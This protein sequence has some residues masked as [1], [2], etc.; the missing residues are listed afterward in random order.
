LHG[1]ASV[2]DGAITVDGEATPEIFGGGNQL[3]ATSEANVSIGECT[4]AS[5]DSLRG[6]LTPDGL[7]FPVE[8]DQEHCFGSGAESFVIV[9]H[10][11]A[12]VIV[13][14]G[15]NNIVTNGYLRYADNA[16]V[17][18]TLLAPTPASRVRIMLGTEATPSVS[19]IGHGDETLLDLVRP[20]VWMA[21]T[22][23]ALAF[24]VFCIARGV[25]PGRAVRE[26]L[27]TPIAGNELVVATGNLMQ[28]AQHDQ[29]AGWLV[30]G[31]LYR[32]L[33]AHYRTPP[34]IS[35]DRL[36]Q[37]VGERTGVDQHELRAVLNA[38]PAGDSTVVGGGLLQLSARI[39][40][41][42]ARTLTVQRTSTDEAGRSTSLTA[43]AS[44]R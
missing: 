42:R 20:G 21:L 34:G 33:V 38:G 25:R 36:A 12:V 40:N 7:L 10:V 15:D 17:V 5:L 29:R 32:Q 9:R 41:L 37:L 31:E 43:Q 2:E 26:L 28:R 1:G 14:L 23:L 3:P 11:G 18:T 35:I 30:R 6:V 22:Q 13:G 39:E 24:V 44:D 8:G 19:D 27:P 16:G 4:I